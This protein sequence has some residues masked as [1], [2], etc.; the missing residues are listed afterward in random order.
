MPH[1]MDPS[2]LDVDD[3]PA[4]ARL[5]PQRRVLCREHGRVERHGRPPLLAHTPF[6]AAELR[7][8]RLRVVAVRE[9]GPYGR[10]AP[11]QA[12]HDVSLRPEVP[13]VFGDR[14]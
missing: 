3:G 2:E 14:S 10:A 1:V 7:S 8:G 9:D 4:L 13:V 12:R 5:L 6:E 11:V